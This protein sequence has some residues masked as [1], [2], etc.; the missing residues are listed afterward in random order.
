MAAPVSLGLVSLFEAYWCHHLRW[1]LVNMEH[2]QYLIDHIEFSN[3]RVL[4]I[5]LNVNYLD[6]VFISGCY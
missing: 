1:I 3:G 5:G 4:N 2:H 6:R